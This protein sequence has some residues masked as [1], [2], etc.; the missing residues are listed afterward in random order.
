MGDKY[1][2]EVIDYERDMKSYH[3]MAIYSGVG[4][5]K[6]RFIDSFYKEDEEI[7]NPQMTVLVITSR[8]AKADE[9]LEENEIDVK[10]NIGRWGNVHRVKEEHETEAEFREKYKKYLRVIEDGNERHFIYQQSVVCT[11]AFIERYLQYVYKPDDIT[12]HLWELFDMIVVDEA[13]SLILDASYQSSS[14]YVYDL[15]REYLWRY[16]QGEENYHLY[17]KCKHMV[18]MTG[19]PEHLKEL[20]VV[21]KHKL[22]IID[23]REECKNVVPKNIYFMNRKSVRK[24]LEAGVKSGIRSIYFAQSITS[25]KNLYDKI[26]IDD[27]SVMALSFSK[28]EKRQ[29][30]DTKVKEVMEK[31]EERIKKEGLLPDTVQLLLSTERNKEGIN[32]KDTDITNLYVESKHMGDI[33]QMAGRVREG[34]ENM[35]VILDGGREADKI[36]ESYDAMFSFRKLVGHNSRK[37]N[38]LNDFWEET[39]AEKGVDLFNNR[40]ALTTAYQE[41]WSS[42]FVDFVHDKFEYIRY[43]YFRNIFEFYLNRWNAIWD[44]GAA[45]DDLN[46]AYDNGKVTERFQQWF[47]DSNVHP[48]D[49]IIK[50]KTEIDDKTIEKALQYITE[51][52]HAGEMYSYN[53]RQQ[54]VV[55]LNGM[56]KTNYERMDLIFRF[57]KVN[58][59]F[60]RLTKNGTVSKKKIEEKDKDKKLLTFIV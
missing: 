54:F 29:E 23:K 27:K 24:H 21:W 45:Q 26:A 20:D 19:T 9:I 40:N 43:S 7:P 25:I 10:G 8:R 3:F 35:Y 33:V 37:H 39:C 36:L 52:M 60:L 46:Y 58:A 42:D 13:H 51:N 44:Y 50:R 18:L 38:P 30:L 57:L 49:V 56:L 31:T 15:I 32:I 1:L 14:Y 5:G 11:N 41:K 17:P 16:E 4:S 47:P 22:H 48:C 59:K 12:T 6:N 55:E 28:E 2:S 53:E 34:V